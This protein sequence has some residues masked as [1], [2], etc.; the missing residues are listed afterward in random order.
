MFLSVL[1]PAK[2]G[3]FFLATI[4]TTACMPN[5]VS[6]FQPSVTGGELITAH[7]VPTSSIVE[8]EPEGG[9]VTIRTWA[10]NGDH[11]NQV[12]LF[13][14][15]D[16]WQRIHFASKNFELLDSEK[17]TSVPVASLIAYKAESIE[18][19]SSEPY[20]APP[21]RLALPRFHVQVNAATA[22]PDNFEL[23]APPL[24]LD[25]KEILLPPIH[26]EKQV[27]LGISPFN[28]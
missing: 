7:C 17:H 22:L 25:G 28:C 16:S 2:C 26:Y 11:V 4:M 20:L 15:G 14:Y 1:K 9:L 27:W 3:L 5:A 18:A 12:S 13:F 19:L 10:D 24:V 23:Q 6:Y 8:F 21:G